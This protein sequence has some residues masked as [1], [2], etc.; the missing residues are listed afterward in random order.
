MYKTL[1]LQRYYNLSDDQ[2]E[3]QINDRMSFMGKSIDASFVEV[4]RQRNSRRENEQIKA[5]EI[6][7]LV[8]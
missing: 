8:R 1:I 2:V 4:P 7:D 5:G 3:Y 6:P